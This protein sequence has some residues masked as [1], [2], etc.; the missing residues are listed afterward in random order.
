MNNILQ[1]VKMHIEGSTTD[2]HFDGVLVDYINASFMIL[3]QLGIGPK[4][5]P[6]SITKDDPKNW[7]DFS[8]DKNIEGAKEYLYRRVQLMFDPPQNSNAMQAAKDIMTEM[9]WRIND[10][11]DFTD[12]FK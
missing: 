7:S 8:N 1:D 12:S 6:F 3:W 4:D 9:E 2:D 5:K 10:Y 11:A